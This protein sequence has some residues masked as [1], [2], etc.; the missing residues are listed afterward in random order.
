MKQLRTPANEDET[1]S[2]L[3]NASKSIAAK[4]MEKA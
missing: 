3:T 4:Q 2:V 1:L